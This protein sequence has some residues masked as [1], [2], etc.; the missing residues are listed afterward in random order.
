MN[1][2]LEINLMPATADSAKSFLGNLDRQIAEL[3]NA[4]TLAKTLRGAVARTF[5]IDRRD[6]ATPMQRIIDGANRSLTEV[7]HDALESELEV[8]VVDH[9]SAKGSAK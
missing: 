5:G 6:G 8:V 1:Q 9:L 2:K 7:E 4:L 3:D